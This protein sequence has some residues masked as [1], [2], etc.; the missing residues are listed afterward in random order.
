MDISEVENV[1]N[2]ST[3]EVENADLEAIIVT[4]DCKN[5]IR[6][7][8]VSSEEEF[9]D[10]KNRKRKR[11]KRDV[12]KEDVSLKQKRKRKRNQNHELSRKGDVSTEED[13]KVSPKR[14]KT[15]SSTHIDILQC[16]NY[17]ES[18]SFNGYSI[19]EINSL[20]YDA[21]TD[22]KIK[23]YSPSPGRVLPIN[24][25]KRLLK[26]CVKSSSIPQRDIPSKVVVVADV[27]FKNSSTFL[28]TDSLIDQCKLDIDILI[29]NGINFCNTNYLN[30]WLSSTPNVDDGIFDRMNDCWIKPIQE[31]AKWLNSKKLIRLYE[32][33]DFFK[34]QK[35]IFRE[36]ASVFY[37]TKSLAASKPLKFVVEKKYAKLDSLL[38]N[39]C[40][41]RKPH[42]LASILRI[43]SGKQII[44]YK[45]YIII[46]H[47][48]NVQMYQID[49]AANIDGLLMQNIGD[50]IQDPKVLTENLTNSGIAG[51]ELCID[52]L[53][54][55]LTYKIDNVSLVPSFKALKGCVAC[56]HKINVKCNYKDR[57]TNSYFCDR[58]QCK[59]RKSV[60]KSFINQFK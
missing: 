25:L 23:L 21:G 40:K 44:Y 57:T 39:F 58:T 51:T 48:K 54:D 14:R 12:F 10:C 7:R 19:H 30:N 43:L 55:F 50:K 32:F 42:Y 27:I 37:M 46:L 2:V 16:I 34:N 6:K 53:M 13:I 24:I 4:N 49:L 38:H 9:E 5:K 47:Q 29:E 28:V 31:N 26:L 3:E 41:T 15:L 20:L 52:I 33:L 18:F 8:N 36:L 17:F 1:A 35:H 60:R 59:R 11:R 22:F 56:E 45:S